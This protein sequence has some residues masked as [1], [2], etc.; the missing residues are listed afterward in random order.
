M[1]RR[2]ALNVILFLALYMPAFAQNMPGLFSP[3]FGLRTVVS[4]GS[5]VIT[6][7]EN[8]THDA[9]IVVFTETGIALGDVAASDKCIAVAFT[10]YAANNP[11]TVSGVTIAGVA[12]SDMD[13]NGDSLTA[14]IVRD[15][16]AVL[17]IAS[18]WYAV[19]PAAT[20]SG[21]IE[22]T[23]SSFMK[24]IG[25]SVYYVSGNSSCIPSDGDFNTASS[26]TSITNTINVPGNGG[27]ISVAGYRDG[28]AAAT[29]TWSG[30]TEDYDTNIG[31]TQQIISAAHEVTAVSQSGHL[32]TAEVGASRTL[33][34]LVTA[35]F[36]P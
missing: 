23:F 19:I 6:N 31:T 12:A 35:A 22:I 24:R 18:I 7:T 28:A 30:T 5:V 1:M 20:T 32:I 16:G 10:G 21:T 2:L 15:S 14:T 4:T 26:D 33:L 3:L 36:S 8:G 27:S 11:R 9:T 13:V 34:T 29:T 25:Y 17:D